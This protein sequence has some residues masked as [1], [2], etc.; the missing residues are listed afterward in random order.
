M[1]SPPAPPD[2]ND[3]NAERI[4]VLTLLAAIIGGLLICVMLTMPFLGALTWA[5]TLAVLFSPLQ[6]WLEKH[7]R[8]PGAAAAVT[9]FAAIITVAVP[10]GL[11]VNRLLHGA[12]SGAA[13]IQSELA[14]GALQLPP[15][16]IKLEQQIDLP[17]I[18]NQFATTV[19]NAGASFLRG[20]LRQAVEIVLTFYILFYFLRDSQR[21][22]AML[23]RLLPLKADEVTQLFRRA[24]DTV[25][26]II[27]GTIMVA[28][29]QGALA[30]L[31]FWALGLPA[32]LF[33]GVVMSLLAIIPVLGTFV[34]WIPEAV[35]LALTGEEMKAAI[36]ALWGALVVSEI[37]NVFRP[38]LVGNRLKLH[39]VPTFIAIIGGLLFFGAPGIVLGPMTITITTFLL[40]VFR[41][42]MVRSSP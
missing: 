8:Y 37:D 20:S 33:W 36:L 9:V 23:R 4:S 42:R 41:Q 3:R 18:F 7:L 12:A 2:F 10:A 11:V 21:A 34:I 6:A 29:L 16:L 13:F 40:T 27:Y 25:R 17:G 19:S 14:A 35:Y 5:F 15:F 39:T 24:T 38:I 31:M 32:P 28:A 1:N 30:G 26:A 22:H